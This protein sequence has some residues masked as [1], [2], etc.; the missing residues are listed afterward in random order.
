[1]E[2]SSPTIPKE[3]NKRVDYVLSL[4][5]GWCIKEIIPVLNI[6]ALVPPKGYECYWYAG[7]YKMI[8]LDKYGEV[9][10]D[11]YFYDDDTILNGRLKR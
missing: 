5:K 11:D 9:K 1:M 3:I 4:K 6:K 10:I 2:S 8:N 7:E